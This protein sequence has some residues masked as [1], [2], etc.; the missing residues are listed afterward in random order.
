MLILPLNCQL[1]F[2]QQTMVDIINF[3]SH[4]HFYQIDLSSRLLTNQAKL[5]SLRSKLVNLCCE[6]TLIQDV[7]LN[8]DPKKVGEYSSQVHICATAE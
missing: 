8:G 6:F 2:C 7:T 4:T 1:T 3:S 5:Y